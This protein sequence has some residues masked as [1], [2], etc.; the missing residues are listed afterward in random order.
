[1]PYHFMFREY[2]YYDEEPEDYIVPDYLEYE[3]TIYH[4]HCHI[5]VYRSRTYVTI[6]EALRDYH[7]V[8]LESGQHPMPNFFENDQYISNSYERYNNYRRKVGHEE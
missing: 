2:I 6:D 7:R 1:M 8:I 5:V 4:R 3:D